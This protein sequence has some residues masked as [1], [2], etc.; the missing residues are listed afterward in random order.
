M[1]ITFLNPDTRYPILDIGIIRT[2]RADLEQK[3]PLGK[4]LYLKPLADQ[5]GAL[6]Q[7][8]YAIENDVRELLTAAP[9]IL[10]TQSV[11][12]LLNEI[13]AATGSRPGANAVSVVENYWDEI[14][15]VIDQSLRK[16]HTRT[17]ALSSHLDRLDEWTQDDV[18]HLISDH[19]GQRAA[20][21]QQLDNL[22]KRRDELQADKQS[23]ND[24]MHAYEGKTVLDRWTPILEDM[25]KVRPG[26]SLMMALQ[27]GVVGVVNI[28]RI[29]SEAVRYDDLVE[30]QAV[31][32]E[33]LIE[34]QARVTD[35]RDQLSTL[36]ARNSQLHGI[37]GIEAIK[38]RYATELRKLTDALDRFLTLRERK[39]NE[40]VS[41]FAPAF[42]IQADA[43]SVWLTNLGKKWK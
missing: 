39:A 33:K 35:Y 40:P 10:Q 19:E 12:Q 13:Q 29:A 15:E 43:L 3:L 21:Q 28:L 26:K 16:M 11:S 30:A 25:L 8:F 36:N 32:H 4:Y 34:Q 6:R 9:V 1:T 18:S 5:L 27:A 7:H 22:L 20:L 17:S 38:Q 37:E 42:V 14:S 31:A 41:D 23:I 2:S 24:A